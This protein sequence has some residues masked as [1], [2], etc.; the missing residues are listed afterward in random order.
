MGIANRSVVPGNWR[1]G[2][3]LRIK[4]HEGVWRDATTFFLTFCWCGP[5]SWVFIEFFAILLL[6]YVL[7]FWPQDMWDLSS[8]TRDWTCTPCIGRWR[9]NHWVTR[10][11]PL[12]YLDCKDFTQLYTSVK[13]HRN[14]HTHK[15]E[16][17]LLII[18]HT[19]KV[20][21]RHFYQVEVK[22]IKMQSHCYYAN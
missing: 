19:Q 9:L 12:L 2:E 18:P 14:A 10:E 4:R 1:S 5:F 22:T 11:V 20:N 6:F 15:G 16:F 7:V 3:R 13:T 21:E 17:Y 8:L